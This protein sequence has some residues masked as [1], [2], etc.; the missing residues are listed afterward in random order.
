MANYDSV[1][2]GENIIKTA[3]DS[4]GR[5]DVLVNN[6]GILRD[7]SFAKMSNEDWDLVHQVHLQGAY[8]TTRA[9]WEYFRQ[10]K[11]G[12]IIN[13][14]STAGV[15]GN[16]GQANYSAAKSGLIGFTNTL[17]IEGARS[18]IHTNTIVPVAGSRLTEGILPPG[19]SKF[20]RRHGFMYLGLKN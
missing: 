20:R 10:Q 12:R 16:F 14:A 1:T 18:N 17:A 11:Y 7:K 3:I 19:R 9:A 2:Q 15:L 4:F 6:A 5:V 13:T 8:R